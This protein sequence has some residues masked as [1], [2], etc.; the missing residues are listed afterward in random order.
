MRKGSLTASIVLYAASLACIVAT[1]VQAIRGSLGM[2]SLEFVAA[3]AF[4]A[5]T[6]VAA[7]VLMYRARP[8]P[9]EPAQEAQ[10]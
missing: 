8:A 3:A 2:W 10:S 5:V 6:A 1:A 9:A 4:H 7:S